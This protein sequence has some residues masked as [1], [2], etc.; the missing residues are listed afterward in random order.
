MS[1]DT[2]DH[3]SYSGASPAA[4]QFHYDAGSEFFRLWLGKTMTYT[5]ARFEE[6]EAGDL[7]PDGLDRAQEDK[8]RHHLD[9]IGA[10]PGMRILDIGCGWGTLMRRAVE[11]FGVE[12]ATGLTLS[13]EQYEYVVRQAVPRVDIRLQS[14]EHFEPPNLFDGIVSVGSFEAFAKPTLTKEQKIA[15]YVNFFA[16]C[17]KW[18]A[19]GGRLSLQTIAWGNVPEERHS[20][21]PIQQFF[22]DS[23]L[24]Y[25][26]E[27]IEA[28]RDY[29]EVLIFEN[30][31]RDYEFTLRS[32][33]TNLRR[34]KQEAIRLVGPDKYDFYDRCLQGGAR[35]FQRRKYYLCRFSFRR[36]QH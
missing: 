1:S 12:A 28:S 10:G 22:P 26:E 3:E 23:D 29:F 21:I 24:P 35:L 34:H 9:A 33:L 14:Y 27:V 36:L 25:I 11:D 16:L 5:A 17:H 18:L 32:W 31:R 19:P 13:K 2:Q 30:R 20:E 7:V 15:A 6:G 8:V 4:I